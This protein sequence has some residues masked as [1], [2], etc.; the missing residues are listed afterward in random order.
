MY[1]HSLCVEQIIT[2]RNKHWVYLLN[3]LFTTLVSLQDSCALCIDNYRTDI[4]TH[5]SSIFN[6]YQLQGYTDCSEQPSALYQPNHID[7]SGYAYLRILSVV[8]RVLI[9]WPVATKKSFRCPRVTFPSLP[10][11]PQPNQTRLELNFI[12]LTNGF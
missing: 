9:N 7:Y 11:S 4:T 8:M 1:I 2:D 5:C 3:S 6:D 12:G 10:P